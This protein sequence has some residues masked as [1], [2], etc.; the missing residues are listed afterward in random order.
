MRGTKHSYRAILALAAALL[1]LLIFQVA[2]AYQDRVVLGGY[3]VDLVG[4][5][6]N[7]N[8]V[9]WIYA[10]SANA[11]APPE[12]GL[13]HWT[14]ALGSCYTITFPP[15][16]QV[17]TTRDDLTQYGCGSTYTCTVGS[18]DVV[19]G[20]DPTLGISGQKWEARDG[21]LSASNL[22]TH[23]FTMTIT[24][25]Q[26]RIGYTDVGVKYGTTTVTGQIKG[27]VCDPTAVGLTSFSATPRASGRTIWIL[28]VLPLLVLAGA[29]LRAGRAQERI[30][31]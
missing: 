19:R 8:D 24:A 5:E 3:T 29:V 30:H 11:S 7:G 1:P 16:G 28:G 17:Y 26:L 9:T 27:P 12:R 31:R 15:T 13:S 23:I 6:Q 22:T 25:P 18:Y 10:V 20:T 4:Y 2:L 14:L 21:Q